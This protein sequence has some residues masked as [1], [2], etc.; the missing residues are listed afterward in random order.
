MKIEWSNEGVSPDGMLALAIVATLLEE[1][2]EKEQKHL[3]C[4]AMNHLPKGS[5]VRRNESRRML[6]AMIKQ[7][8]LT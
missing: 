8:E 5:G 2:D 1:L 6:S 7:Y 4:R 3:L